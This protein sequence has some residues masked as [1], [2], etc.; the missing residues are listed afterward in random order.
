MRCRGWT[1]VINDN[2]VSN[3]LTFA[4]F[5]M[6]IMTAV[7]GALLS[8]PFGPPLEAAGLDS[9]MITLSF[10]GFLMGFAVGIV[11]INV[12]NSAVAM[13]FV[14]LAENPAVLKVIIALF[15]LQIMS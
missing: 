3:A 8:I 15:A 9:P 1:A 7:V 10:L 6:A 13:V 4:L 5:G 14:C 2:L 12:I 11:L